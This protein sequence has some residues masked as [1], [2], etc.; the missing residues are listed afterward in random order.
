[1]LLCSTG[2]GLYVQM[3]YKEGLELRGVINGVILERV[4]SILALVFLVGATMPLLL[5]PRLNHASLDRVY[6][7][8]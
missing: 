4:A 3:T 2:S 5:L 6:L 8:R 7:R 1:M